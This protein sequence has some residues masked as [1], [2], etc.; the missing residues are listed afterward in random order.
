MEHVGGK[1][2]EAIGKNMSLKYVLFPKGRVGV[3][4]NLKVLV[5]FFYPEAIETKQMLMCSSAKNKQKISLERTYKNVT[6]KFQNL[7]GDGDVREKKIF[8]QKNFLKASLT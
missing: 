7:E 2:R 4:A 5:T 1:V 3:L 8:E 6:Q